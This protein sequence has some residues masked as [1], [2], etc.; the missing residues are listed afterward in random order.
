MRYPAYVPKK[1]QKFLSDEIEHLV[2][3]IVNAED[4]LAKLEFAISNWSNLCEVCQIENRPEDLRR[5]RSSSVRNRD[6]LVSRMDYIKRLGALAPDDERMQEAYNA[7]RRDFTVDGQWLRFINAACSSMHEFA[8]YRERKKRAAELS[9]QVASAADALALS[10]RRLQRTG[11]KLPIEL[12]D[13][14]REWSLNF[15]SDIEQE[16]VIRDIML[17]RNLPKHPDLAA[18]LVDATK[19]ARLLPFPSELPRE[20]S[21]LLFRNRNRTSRLSTCELSATSLRIVPVQL[22]SQ[23][24]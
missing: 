2:P 14:V 15:T 23:S 4:E 24:C 11:V 16:I 7:L 19:A 1:V 10:L 21:T 3:L 17:A 18:L 5:R 6:R 8:E 20:P 9:E 22:V 12:M 13:N